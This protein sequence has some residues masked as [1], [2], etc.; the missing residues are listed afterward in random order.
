MSYLVFDIEGDGIYPSKIWCF[1]YYLDGKYGETT[2]YKEMASLLNSVDYIVGHNIARW[3][4]PHL[5]RILGVKIT[6]KIID[7]LVLSWYVFPNR[8]RYGLEYFGEEYGVPKPKI[9]DWFNLSVEEY[10]HRCTEDVKI[11]VLLWNDIWKIL[12]RLYGSKEK[13]LKLIHYLSFKIDCAVEQERHGWL[14]DVHSTEE[15]LNSLVEEEQFKLA[16]LTKAMPLKPIT[17]TKSKP[18]RMTKADG[19]LTK[20]GEA[21]YELLKFNGKR[22]D[23][24]GSLEIVTGYEEGNP[25]SHIQIK[26]WLFSLEWKPRTYKYNRQDDGSIKEIPQINL[27]AKDGG[28]ICPSIQ[29]LY[30]KEPALELL[31]GLGII[32]HRIS[33][34]KGFLENVDGD[35]YI[36]AKVAGLTNTLRFKHS[37]LVNLPR[38]DKPYGKEI[39]GVLSSPKGYELCG[40]DMAALEDRIKQHYIYKYDP[41]YVNKM[42]VEG[43]DPHLDLAVM[44]GL[45]T[46]EQAENYKDNEKQLK[47]IRSVAKG[48]NYACQYGAFPPRLAIACG[49]DIEQAK[50]LHEGYWALNWAIRAVASSQTI[51]TIGDQMW[52]L[53]PVNEF[54]YSLRTEKDIF[55][56]LV[57]GTASYVF[58]TWVRYI[59]QD[60]AK[61][62]GQF[63]DEIIVLVKEGYRDQV[64]SYFK[65]CIDQTNNQ[66]K[67]NRDLGIDIQFGKNYS[68]I[69]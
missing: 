2:D 3:D 63:H 51:K 56:T 23:F 4:V 47:P 45:M 49:I 28:G 27:E 29:E 68:E 38:A 11:T 30:T 65:R 10:T 53:N 33:I 50:T 32:Q 36:Q 66:L 31:E 46:K 35:S 14:L 64:T 37:V 62:I 60:G 17:K 41:D 52:L 34:L 25:S 69:H 48:G 58:D 67:L 1:C 18:K 5:E 26:D 57:Q 8:N 42:N 15:L 16:E 22:K 55:S 54:W 6:S 12:N 39:R 43:Y 13:A 59:R 19:S 44:A 7:T 20:L 61:V 9:D 21:W 24:E 40:S